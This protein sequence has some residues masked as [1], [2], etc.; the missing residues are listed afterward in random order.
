MSICTQ[1]V[2]IGYNWICIIVSDISLI[3]ARERR[4][5]GWRNLTMSAKS[6]SN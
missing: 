3:C 4:F 5:S 2:K 1:N 6:T